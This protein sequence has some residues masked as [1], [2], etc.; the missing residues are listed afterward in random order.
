MKELFSS[1]TPIDFTDKVDGLSGTINIPFNSF[2][3][4]GGRIVVEQGEYFHGSFNLSFELDLRGR[5]KMIIPINPKQVN[6]MITEEGLLGGVRSWFAKFGGC[7]NYP[8]YF[9]SNL[10]INILMHLCR[11]YLV[12][13][14][15]ERSPGGFRYSMDAINMR[16]CTPF[17]NDLKWV[18]HVEKFGAAPIKNKRI[19]VPFEEDE[20]VVVDDDAGLVDSVRYTLLSLL[21]LPVDLSIETFL[22]ALIA[23]ADSK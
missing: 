10:T 13:I 2:R 21:G 12:L 22:S 15:N 18:E 5:C 7:N 4:S 9:D 1:S 20:S 11:L 14:G 6:N 8:V 16:G 17:S 3:R 19:R 23:Q